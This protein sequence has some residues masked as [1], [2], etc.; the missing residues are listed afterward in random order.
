MSLPS[1]VRRIET[2]RILYKID[3][4]VNMQLTVTE[5]QFHFCYKQYRG[6]SISYVFSIWSTVQYVCYLVSASLY[7]R[8]VVGISLNH[9]FNWHE[10]GNYEADSW[11]LSLKVQT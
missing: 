4:I 10:P 3:R 11:W 7:N 2:E 8:A 6:V 1:A 5:T 9:H